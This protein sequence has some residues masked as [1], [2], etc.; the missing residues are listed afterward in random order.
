MIKSVPDEPFFCSWSGGKDSCLALYRAI[1]AGAKAKYLFTTCIEDGNR[2][3]I[4]G[5]HTDVIT[6]QAE[7]IGISSLRSH[8]SWEN[9]EKNFIFNI[10]ELQKEG[11]N[12]GVFGDIFLANV[13][14]WSETICKN[15]GINAHYPLW[16][17]N[18]MDLLNEFWNLGFK[19]LI[20]VVNSKKLD[21]K[22]LG[23]ELNR[24]LAEEFAHLGIDVCGENG[25][26]HT[27]VVDGPIFSHP[28]KLKA[29]FQVLRSNYWFQDFEIQN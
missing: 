11:I 19:T 10:K 7:A 1:Q 28:L 9:Y 2:T 5:L 20:A 3:R 26:F 21:K 14:N 17:D 27:V 6:A 23:L 24:E 15:T 4:H 16:Q 22:Y 29:G 25:E 13:R 12:T 8:T 18:P